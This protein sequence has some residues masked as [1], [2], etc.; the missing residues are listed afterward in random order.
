M[1]ILTDFGLFLSRSLWFLSPGRR[2]VFAHEWYGNVIF[3]LKYNKVYSL[4]QPF[5]I[6][7]VNWMQVVHGVYI[8]L[9]PC[10]VKSWY[11]GCCLLFYMQ[12]GAMADDEVKPNPKCLHVLA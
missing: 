1:H 3:C 5:T 2:W 8:I 6:Q 12:L 9:E 11:K 7:V 10:A 4:V